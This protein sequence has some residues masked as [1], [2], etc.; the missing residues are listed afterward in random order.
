RATSAPL[1]RGWWWRRRA[2]ATA[3]T[4]PRRWLVVAQSS[5]APPARHQ[6]RLV[7]QVSCRPLCAIDFES[8]HFLAPLRMIVSEFDKHAVPDP[9][10]DHLTAL[11]LGLALGEPLDA[12]PRVAFGCLGRDS[13]EIPVGQSPVDGVQ[14]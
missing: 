9:S 6:I 3:T 7:A 5:V 13:V 2:L 4:S 8:G 12:P 11:S 1:R 14:N 10:I